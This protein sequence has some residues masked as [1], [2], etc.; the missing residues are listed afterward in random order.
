[1]KMLASF[2]VLC[3]AMASPSRAS[4][5][6]ALF[7]S[8]DQIR[9]TIQAPLQTLIRNRGNDSPISGTLT[10]PSGQALPISLQLR[11][12]TRRTSEICDFPPLRVTFT[13]PPPAITPLRSDLIALSWEQRRCHERG[14][15]FPAGYGSGRRRRPPEAR[16]EGGAA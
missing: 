10:D 1:M 15:V 3:L 11:G 8:N 7:A 12:I 9:L 2:A 5:E 13:A 14:P 16:S 4:A 6:K